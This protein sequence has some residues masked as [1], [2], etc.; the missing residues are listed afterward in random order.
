MAM[1]SEFDTVDRFDFKEVKTHGIRQRK[2]LSKSL[3]L[4]DNDDEYIISG[5]PPP[6]DP[7]YINRVNDDIGDSID[8][9]IDDSI[10]DW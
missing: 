9:G 6:K 8:D 10:D 3:Q 5:P 1:H 7:R 4:P 2:S